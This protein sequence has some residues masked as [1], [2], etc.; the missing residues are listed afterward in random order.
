M[1]ICNFNLCMIIAITHRYKALTYSKLTDYKECP[2]WPMRCP[3]HCSTEVK[4]TRSTLQV[5]L[6]KDYPEQVI[7]YQFRY[8]CRARLKRK[9]M[10]Q[11][12]T[13]HIYEMKQV[14]W[15][16]SLIALLLS[17]VLCLLC[18]LIFRPYVSESQV[19]QV[20]QSHSCITSVL[21][22]CLAIYYL[23]S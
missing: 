19:S 17:S 20:C 2:Q 3:N 5:H 21:V 6:K 15:W 4:L 16:L 22:I 14:S 9:D 18:F 13:D 8:A 7:T 10:A 23:H 1:H 12:M 11:H